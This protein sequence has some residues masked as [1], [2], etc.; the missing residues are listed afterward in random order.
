M[1]DLLGQLH[2]GGAELSGEILNLLFATSD[3]LEDLA[4]DKQSAQIG[5]RLQDLYGEYSRR[6][7]DASAGL[8]RLAEAVETTEFGGGLEADTA[9]APE[10]LEAFALEAEDHLQAIGR[11][12]RDL[13][14]QPKDKD[15]TL[16]VR[17]RVHT[18]KGAAAMVGITAASGLA[19]R[20]E[21]L[22]DEVHK[23]NIELT[24][25]SRDLLFTST[26][27][28]EDITAK[29]GADSELQS[30]LADI[31]GAYD[32]F[33]GAPETPPELPTDSV[34]AQLLED[35]QV[36]DLTQ[37]SAAGSGAREAAKTEAVQ[38]AAPVTSGK[39]VRIPLER[40]D[41]LVRLVSELVVN[42]STFEQHYSRYIHEVDELNLSVG[43]LKRIASKFE[44]E[45]AVG[46]LVAQQ[47]T[48]G[49]VGAG[50]PA[51]FARTAGESGSRDFDTLEFDRYSDIHL[52]SRDLTETSSDIGSVGTQFGNII[53]DFDSYLNRLSR[54]SS[55]VQDK[56][57]RFRMVPVASLA[58]RLHRTVRVTASTANKQADLTIE[59]ENVELDKTVLE[60]M[61][62]PLEHLLRNAV[63]HGIELPELRRA[64]GKSEEGQLRVRT[65]HEGTQVV[66]QVSDDGAGLQPEL[67][68]SKTI[69]MGLVSEAE[70]ADLTEQDLYGF[71]FGAGFSTAKEISEVS[72]RGVGLDIV[73]SAVTRMK[74]RVSVE[75]TPG[76]G[77]TFTIRLP[78]TLAITRV[79][80]V[81]AY[82][83]VFAV[84]LGA[85]IQIVRVERNRIE[86][87]G[88]KEVIR[89]DGRVIPTAYLGAAL[90]V[91]TAWEPGNQRLPV[92]ILQLG[93]RQIG[94]VVD[95]LI[96]AR[97]VVVKTLGNVLRRVHGLTGATLMGDGSVVLIINPS[98]LVQESETTITYGESKIEAESSQASRV[99]DVLIVDDSLSVRRVL[100]NLVRNTGWNPITA[101]DGV[102]ALEVLQ[103]SPKKPD[104]ILLDIEMP[105]MDG[106]ELTAMLRGQPEH[107]NLPI[108]MLTSRAGQKH[109]QKAFELG[110]TDYL[111]KPYQDESLLSVV[112]R[113]VRESRESTEASLE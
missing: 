89:I 27:A 78:M 53:G 7:V 12:L 34:L 104:V 101:K 35:D 90:G 74:G 72:G 48:V 57:M 79:L 26:D 21:D 56:L 77:V 91:E 112:R 63:D 68:R 103:A 25:V 5:R 97:E 86:R 69:S 23:D 65:Y 11:L 40:L 31:L 24:D 59:G 85:V 47:E 110:A 46:A 18:L 36:V 71:V 49:S 50:V 2:E 113:V 58:S 30:Q 96:E 61:V 54:L 76:H 55:E 92:L 88:Q 99:Y 45:Y 44:T 107:Q 33:L 105:R 81:K 82:G 109:R 13:V 100:S 43:R 98:D 108:V 14:K 4:S 73:R 60:E 39:V 20:M 94:L 37:M 38:A 10:I 64:V 51:P 95:E 75:S 1:E 17:R 106:Y 93:D 70:A 52:L 15:L 102:E 32:E 22:L 62:G 42:R 87:I 19:H 16:E 67:I 9:V 28:L 41:E 29:G 80:L 3:A 83:S 8:P 84:P 66:I 6:L 111:V